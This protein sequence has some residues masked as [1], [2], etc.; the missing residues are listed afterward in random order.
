VCREHAQ[1]LP[2]VLDIFRNKEGAFQALVVGDALY[3]G[4]CEPQEDPISM[5]ILDRA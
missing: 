5:E 3:C 1:T 2:H 4:I